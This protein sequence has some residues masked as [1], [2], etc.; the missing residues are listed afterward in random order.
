MRRDTINYTAVGAFVL[1]LFALVLTVLYQITGRRGPTDEYHAQYDNVEGIK[2]GT[3]DLYEG[4]PIG[5]VSEVLPVKSA[6]GTRFRLSL[7]VQNGWRIPA[8]SEARV[9]KSGLLSAVAI[10]IR[11][12]DSASALSPGAEITSRG[13]SDRS[14]VSRSG[15]V[16]TKPREPERRERPPRIVACSPT[17]RSLPSRDDASVRKTWSTVSSRHSFVRASTLSTKRPVWFASDAALMAPAETPFRTPGV[18]SGWRRA[19]PRSTPTW[20]AA[21]APPPPRIS[22]RSAV[23]FI[24]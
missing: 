18:R 16:S 15:A 6:Q 8:D 11:E 9:V 22:P 1:V 5:Q 12:G 24:A 23:G 19:M 20:Y 17:L 14:S 3:P 10:D 13:A 21:R 2:Y 4:Y 7:A